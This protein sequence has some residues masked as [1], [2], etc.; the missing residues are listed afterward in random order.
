LQFPHAHIATA[1]RGLS[2]IERAELLALLEAAQEDE[3]LQPV[4]DRLGKDRTDARLVD[5]VVTVAVAIVAH[6]SALYRRCRSLPTT[7]PL[8]L[9]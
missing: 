7:S 5:Y 9:P 1:L 8:Q 2:Q 6:Q 3:A 4:D